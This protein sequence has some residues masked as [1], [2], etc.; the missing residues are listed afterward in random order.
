MNSLLCVV[1]DTLTHMV[2]LREHVEELSSFTKA[3][4]DGGGAEGQA[5]TS[6]RKHL[7]AK[8]TELRQVQSRTA[9]C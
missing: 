4:V 7:Q 5:S 8:D 6:L 9:H 1:Q 3:H 2:F